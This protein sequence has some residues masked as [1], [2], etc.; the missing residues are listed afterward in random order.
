MMGSTL[1]RV[2]KKNFSMMFKR[3]VIFLLTVLLLFSPLNSTLAR[4]ESYLK[5]RDILFVYDDELSGKAIENIAAMADILT[6]MGYGTSYRTVSESKGLLDRFDSILFYHESEEIN[7]SFLEELKKLDNKIMVVGGGEI[8]ELLQAVKATVKAIGMEDTTV[9]FS[10]PFYNGTQTASG[11]VKAD[12]ATILQG[13]P[14]YT[15]GEAAA[16]GKTAALCASSGRF[17]GIAVFDSES[18]ILKAVFSDQ[19]SRWKW[20]YK[21]L[22]NS[23]PQHIIFDNVYPFVNNQ[24]MLKVVEML[25]QKGITYSITVMPVYQ[26]SEYPAMKHFCELLRFAQSKGASIILKA[27]LINTARPVLE[28]INKRIS[29]AM[30]AY[31]NYGVYPIAIEAPNNW[32]NETLGQNVLK[33]FS[34]VVLYNDNQKSSWTDQDGYNKIYL[35]GHHFITPALFNGNLSSNM[36][37]T[38]P[39]AIFLDMNTDIDTLEQQIKMIQDSEVSLKSLRSGAHSVYTDDQVISLKNNMLTVNGKLQS[40]EFTPFTYESSYN[41][42]R[43]V[44][45]RLAE[46][47]ARG[48]QRLLIVVTGI[49][50]LFIVF[51]VVARYQNRRRFLYKSDSGHKK[52]GGDSDWN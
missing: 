29:T 52:D 50:I 18:D 10:Y 27:P 3:R 13:K 23:Y 6:Y 19:I 43:G 12:R 25:E 49:S 46:S 28:E 37:N 39:T 31:V 14:Q 9:R 36:I 41:Y 48:N 32:I 26:N 34:T 22:P 15:A 44:I 51:I 21:N 5:A 30:S 47:I 35:D 24:K 7:S 4:D 1:S 8:T 40:F 16:G 17:T 45:G 20:P 2:L 33:R 11:F 42:N 38:Y